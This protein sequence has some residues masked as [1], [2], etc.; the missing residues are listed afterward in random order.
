METALMRLT[1]E[2]NELARHYWR[3]IQ[4]HVRC[5]RELWDALMARTET[6]WYL[7]AIDTKSTAMATVLYDPAMPTDAYEIRAELAEKQHGGGDG[8][9]FGEAR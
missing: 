7:N 4:I 2:Y 5:G 1:T 3:P 9:R 6:G 8:R